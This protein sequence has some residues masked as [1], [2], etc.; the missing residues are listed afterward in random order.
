MAPSSAV[1]WPRLGLSVLIGVI[2]ALATQA[3]GVPGGGSWIVACWVLGAVA[4][5][6]WP[7]WASFAACVAGIALATL[8]L[9]TA[10]GQYAGL[11]WLVVA[12]E[13]AILGHGFLVSATVGRARR[14]RS[15][16]DQRVAAGLIAA[17]GLVV[18]FVL[19]AQDFARNPP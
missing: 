2:A 19:V 9:V 14:L 8:V 12:C 5:A 1:R 4:A 7:G 10:A 18:A 11:A 13:A 17:I 6:I 15:L 3:L 16:R